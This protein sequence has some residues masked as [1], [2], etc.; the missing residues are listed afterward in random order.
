MKAILFALLAAAAACAGARPLDALVHKLDDPAA[1]HEEI[2]ALIDAFPEKVPPEDFYVLVN[3]LRHGDRRVV[4]AASRTLG[5][6]LTASKADEGVLRQLL[7]GKEPVMRQT[8]V[9]A[10]ERLWSPAERRAVIDRLTDAPASEPAP[11]PAA[12]ATAPAPSPARNPAECLKNFKIED[13]LIAETFAREEG[14]DVIRQMTCRVV[15]AKSMKPCERLA[16]LKLRNPNATWTPLQLCR[17]YSLTPL[18]LE[19]LKTD[20]ASVCPDLTDNFENVAAPLRVSVCRA[21][22][23]KGA[24]AEVCTG[25]VAASGGVVLSP[26]DFGMCQNDQ[27]LRGVAAEKDCASPRMTPI[28]REHCLETFRWNAGCAASEAALGRRFCGQ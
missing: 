27:L 12:A 15:A 16:G 25:A 20:D 10:V 8:G 14:I 6:S 2:D 11:P 7:N 28:A 9:E 17:Q 22:F 23:A 1:R 21:L 18:L 3:L 5:R 13:M 19:A 4:A 24:P 26:H